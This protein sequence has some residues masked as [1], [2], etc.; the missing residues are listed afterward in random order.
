MLSIA[1]PA[2]ETETIDT[3]RAYQLT[4]IQGV[5]SVKQYQNGW[6]IE[7]SDQI[8]LRL[9]IAEFAQRSGLLLL[10]IKVESKSLEDYFK[11]LTKN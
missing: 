8:D 3:L 7:S 11:D 4:K 10:T 6:L 1:L 2:A 5:E 9:N